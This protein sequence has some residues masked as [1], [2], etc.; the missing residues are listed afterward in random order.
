[1]NHTLGLGFY[2][3][4]DLLVNI[5]TIILIFLGT[6]INAKCFRSLI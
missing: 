3:D 2:L 6:R 4:L 5:I 1:M